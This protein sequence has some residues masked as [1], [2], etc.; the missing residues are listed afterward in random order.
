MKDKFIAAK[1]VEEMTEAERRAEIRRLELE[2]EKINA[3]MN[4]LVVKYAKAIGDG[5]PAAGLRAVGRGPNDWSY[6][7]K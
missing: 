4:R 1:P 2:R 7:H 6:W 3:E 5:A